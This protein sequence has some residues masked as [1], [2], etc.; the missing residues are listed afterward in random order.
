[1]LRQVGLAVG[2]AALI[3]V[4]GTPHSPLAT[5]VAYQRATWMVAAIAFIGGLVGLGLLAR[6]QQ[7]SASAGASEPV[8]PA[9]AIAAAGEIHR[10]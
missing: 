10:A 1:M 4:L 7:A 9:V 5:L 6:G 2:V 3:A 8:T